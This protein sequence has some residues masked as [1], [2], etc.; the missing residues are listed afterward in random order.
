VAQENNFYIYRRDKVL[1]P[2]RGK[3]KQRGRRKRI[4]AFLSSKLRND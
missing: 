3:R 2:G 1:D 4:E